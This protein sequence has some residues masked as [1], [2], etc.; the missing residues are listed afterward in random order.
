MLV[1]RL[2]QFMRCSGVPKVQ[3]PSATTLQIHRN[4]TATRAFKNEF[5]MRSFIDS[6]CEN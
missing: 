5:R 2:S 6:P 4:L 3:R 1:P